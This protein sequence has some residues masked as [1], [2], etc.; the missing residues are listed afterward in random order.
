ML[1]LH[2]NITDDQYLLC[3][4]RHKPAA[5]WYNKEIDVLFLKFT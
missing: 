3:N 1:D 4:K 5:L 2:D